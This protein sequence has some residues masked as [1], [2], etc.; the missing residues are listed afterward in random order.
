MNKQEFS[1]FLQKGMM[2]AETMLPQI[3]KMAEDF[4]FFQSAQ[5]LL[6]VGKVCYQPLQFQKQL[7]EIAIRVSDRRQLKYLVLRATQQK[8]LFDPPQP[9]EKV[10]Q[11]E[12]L[13]HVLNDEILSESQESDETTSS[14]VATLTASSIPSSYDITKLYVDNTIT[15]TLDEKLENFE[16]FLQKHRLPDAENTDFYK[17]DNWAEKSISKEK[18]P[19]S[20]TLAK[21]YEKQGHA[22]EAIK[23]Y[24]ILMLQNPEKSSYFAAIIE[25]LLNV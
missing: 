21:V 3:E 4:P 2:P 22:D 18:I 5:M 6:A 7:P 19:A 13:I 15:N 11:T 24:K 10:A 12:K 14:S 1:E 8:P 20:E 9:S 17:A 16:H 23:I 25:K